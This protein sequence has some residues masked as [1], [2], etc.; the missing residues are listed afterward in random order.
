MTD[1]ERMARAQQRVATLKGLYIH[2]FAFLSVVIALLALDAA[3][4]GGWWV[5]WVF[6]GWGIG[7]AAHAITTFRRTPQFV[8]QWEKRKL[9]QIIGKMTPGPGDASYSWRRLG[10]IGDGAF[11]LVLAFGFAFQVPWITALWR[12]LDAPI[13]GGYFAAIL[14]SFAAGS[15][16]IAWSG[17]WR[18]AAGGA[19]ALI[20]TCL[21]FAAHVGVRYA[22]GEGE[23]LLIHAAVLT[24]IAALAATTLV[25]SLKSAVSDTQPVP[26]ALRFFFFGFALLVLVCGIAVLGGTPGILPW[27]LG[28][29]TSMLIGWIF[30]GLSAEYAYVALRGGWS[31]ARVLLVGFTV[32]AAAFSVPLLQHF[33]TVEAAYLPSLI[34]NIGV[35]VSSGPLAAHYLRIEHVQRQRCPKVAPRSI[36]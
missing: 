35:L 13:A 23:D 18:A 30:A 33:W 12:W 3:T 19:G 27:D 6:F 7:V 9:R 29:Q 25:S 14:A 26:R 5:Q 22:Q 21:G 36:S 34:V 20:L 11:F 24:G 1:R 16:L 4:G 2:L 32:Y 15:F 31:D 10:F 8:A 17:E 28:E